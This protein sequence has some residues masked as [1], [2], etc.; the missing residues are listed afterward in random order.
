M[1]HVSRNEDPDPA[2]RDDIL[3]GVGAIAEHINEDTRRTNYLL[4]KGLLPAWKWGQRWYSRRSAIQAD[5]D[6]RLAASTTD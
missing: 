2:L 1:P 3:S 4:A 6:R 5:I